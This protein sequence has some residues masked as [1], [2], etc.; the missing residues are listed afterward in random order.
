MEF[1]KITNKNE[2]H[3]EMEYKTGLNVDIK[4]FNPSGDCETGGIYFSRE[5]I[6]SFL[7]YGCWIREVTLPKDE[8]I[9]ENP[10][11]PKKWKTHRIILGKRR[12]IDLEVIKELIE[13]GANIHADDDHALRWASS[14]GHFGVVKFLIEKGSNVHADNDY[15]L[16]WASYNGHLGVVKFLIEKGANVHA[17]NDRALIWASYNGHIKTLKF[18]IEKGANVH[19][20]SDRALRWASLN[21]HLDVIDYLKT[22]D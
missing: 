6:L 13:K 4:P 16:I 9:Y 18:L 20:D 8:E 19:I 5:D 1:Y 21:G 12:K 7:E 17:D 2:I 11:E 10:G 22:I 15:A 3:Y 14:E